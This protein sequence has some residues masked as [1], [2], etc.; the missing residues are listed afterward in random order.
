MTYNLEFPLFNHQN[1]DTSCLPAQPYYWLTQLRPASQLHWN[2]GLSAS[3]RHTT[4][5]LFVFCCQNC[6]FTY[7]QNKWKHAVHRPFTNSSLYYCSLLKAD[8][9]PSVLVHET[10]KQQ[11]HI[12][13]K[14]KGNFKIIHLSLPFETLKIDKDFQDYSDPYTNKTLHRYVP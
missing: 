3:S 7:F 8:I 6:A 2:L 11:G 4:K 9:Y 13:V 12:S 1:T 5:Q 14:D 10:V